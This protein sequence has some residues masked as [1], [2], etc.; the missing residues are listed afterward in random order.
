MLDKLKMIVEHLWNDSDSV[1]P[2]YLE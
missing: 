1:D 2:E